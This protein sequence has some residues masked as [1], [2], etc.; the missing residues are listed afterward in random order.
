MDKQQAM[1][2]IMAEAKTIAVVGFSSK[3]AKA[4]HYVPAYLQAQG[5]RIIPV[6]PY[7]AE[8]LGEKAVGSLD[9]ITESVDLVLLFQPQRKC[10]AIC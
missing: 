7:L 3:S 5:Y 9:E 1:E 4:G 10:A 2:K 6:N 8:G